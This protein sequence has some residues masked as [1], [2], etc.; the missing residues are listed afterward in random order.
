MIEE[1]RVTLKHSQDDYRS[2]RE[3]TSVKLQQADGECQKAAEE[4]AKY[5]QEISVKTSELIY[6]SEEVTRVNT[7]VQAAESE[8]A[9]LKGIVSKLR[10]DLESQMALHVPC[11]D[12]L[13]E[14][15]K[16]CTELRAD[17]AKK[18]HEM[19][20]QAKEAEAKLDAAVRSHTSCGGQLLVTL[21]LTPTRTLI[22][23]LT[24]LP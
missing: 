6:R 17:L 1:L 4:I 16:T 20:L 3:E 18:T 12:R 24:L 7:L 10:S 21:S 9:E 19:G 5:R 23:L 13:R 11:A 14:V 15:D 22:M 2:L 8:C